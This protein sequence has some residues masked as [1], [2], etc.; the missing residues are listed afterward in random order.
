[1]FKADAGLRGVMAVF[2]A[3]PPS[4][5]EEKAQG[6]RYLSHTLVMRQENKQW[7]EA[8]GALVCDKPLCLEKL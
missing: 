7:P 4:L 8:E 2:P 3:L 6:G 5:L 1:M